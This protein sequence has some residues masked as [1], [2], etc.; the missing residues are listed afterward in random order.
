MQLKVVRL[1][2]AELFKRSLKYTNALGDACLPLP[3]L[4]DAL[5]VLSR[6]VFQAKTSGCKRWNGH[7]NH[8]YDLTNL[9][10]H[11]VFNQEGFRGSVALFFFGGFELASSHGV[12]EQFLASHFP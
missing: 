5:G 1:S 10:L 3:K 2:A 8:K 6:E 12:L 9:S 11:R 7:S 4:L